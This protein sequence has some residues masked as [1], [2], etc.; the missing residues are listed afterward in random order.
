MDSDQTA[1]QNALDVLRQHHGTQLS[2]PQ[3]RGEAEMRHTLKQELGCD[4]AT[5]E[6]ILKQLTTTGRL[7][8]VGSAEGDSLPISDGTGPVISMPLTQSADGGAPLITTASPALIMG[9][10][11]KPGGDV[12]DIVDTHEED[13]REATTVGERE[14]VGG[15][16][17]QGYWR[18]S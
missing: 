4:T 11:D 9:I 14:K 10:V 7:A 13:E 1:L 18:I 6:R 8:Y 3:Q 16:R 5:A 2:G 17:T 15:E 12:G